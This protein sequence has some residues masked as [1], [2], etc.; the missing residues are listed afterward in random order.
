MKN[1]K[2]SRAALDMDEEE[3]RQV[4]HH[5]VDKIA[6]FLGNISQRNV[7]KPGA[8]E[9]AHKILGVAPLPD[10]GSSNENVVE[11]ISDL[12]LE[13]LFSM[14]IHDFGDTLTAHPARWVL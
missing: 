11:E 14:V 1:K 6:D 9:I 3:F 2:S 13:H 5:L 12:L 4:G 7:H 8:A 10:T